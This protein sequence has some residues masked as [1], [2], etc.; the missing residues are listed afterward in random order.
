MLK[1]RIF[2]LSENRGQIKNYSVRFG[3]YNRIKT[4]FSDFAAACAFLRRLTPKTSRVSSWQWKR[5]IGAAFAILPPQN[6]QA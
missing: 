2:D 1:R 4:L 3:S 6:D 5:N